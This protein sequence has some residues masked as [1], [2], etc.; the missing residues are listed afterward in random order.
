[1]HAGEVVGGR[2]A[3]ERLA[4]AGGMGAVFRARDL[5]A[6]SAV[7]LKVLRDRGSAELERFIAEAEILARL[8][9][10]GIVRYLAHGRAADGEPFLAMEWLDGEDLAARLLH[11]RLGVQESV[12]VIRRAA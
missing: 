4:G 1:M 7:A 9:H 5:E 12:G 10:P 3:I 6:G 2:F 11:G 8:E